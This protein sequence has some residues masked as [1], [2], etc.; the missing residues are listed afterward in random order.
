MNSKENILEKRVSKV[1]YFVGVYYCLNSDLLGDSK[2]VPMSEG[3][4]CGR[5]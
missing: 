2:I 5:K 3:R 1:T 4:N